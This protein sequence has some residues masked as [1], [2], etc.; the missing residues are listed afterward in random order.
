MGI[1]GPAGWVEDQI[2]RGLAFDSQPSK[3]VAAEALDKLLEEE[4]EEEEEEEEEQQQ[5]A[6]PGR[7]FSLLHISLNYT[8]ISNKTLP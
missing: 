8:L 4:K 6:S 3:P 2:S 1:C 7:I 5:Q